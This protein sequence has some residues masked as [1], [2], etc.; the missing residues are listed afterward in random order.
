MN[1]RPLSNILTI[2]VSVRVTTRTCARIKIFIDDVIMSF[3]ISLTGHRFSPRFWYVVAET[4]STRYMT[5]IC[6]FCDVIIIKFQLKATMHNFSY[7]RV[8]SMGGHL[9]FQTWI[10]MAMIFEPYL[11][12]YSSIFSQT[13]VCCSWDCGLSAATS[14]ILNEMSWTWSNYRF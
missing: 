7:L 4:I 10:C 12:C 8:I 5:L 9:F 6:T 2:H 11:G 3:V 1:F 13:L 14:S